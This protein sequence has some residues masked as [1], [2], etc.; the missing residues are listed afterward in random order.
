MTAHLVFLDKDR[1]AEKL[2]RAGE[3]VARLSEMFKQATV[4]LAEFSRLMA[5]VQRSSGSSHQRRKAR[6]AY[7]RWLS[8]AVERTNRR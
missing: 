5:R 8:S 4:N 2:S 1:I 3:D 6:R 7:V